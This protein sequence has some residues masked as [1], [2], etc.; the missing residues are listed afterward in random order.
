MK[1]ISWR[2]GITRLPELSAVAHATHHHSSAGG[3]MS[4]ELW[5]K[6]SRGGIRSGTLLH[7]RHWG[8]LARQW[9]SQDTN[10]NARV[11]G[12]VRAR[13]RLQQHG[14]LIQGSELRVQTGIYVI[15][16]EAQLELRNQ[17]THNSR[18]YIFLIPLNLSPSL[19]QAHF[20][21][22]CFNKI[23]ILYY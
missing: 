13:L 20:P 22:D 11:A 7:W 6:S 21:P 9:N 17:Q 19:N 16:A 8:P 2:A 12:V 5:S 14:I 23:T 1:C 18:T 10:S 4:A 15:R 3:T